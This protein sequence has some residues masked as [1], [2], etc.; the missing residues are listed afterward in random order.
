MK[1]LRGAI[2]TFIATRLLSVFLTLIGA[3]VLLLMMVRFV[4]GDFASVMLGPRATP[5]LREQITQQM[6]LDRN[7]F[8][9]LWLLLSNAATG[10]FGDDIISHRPILDI[11]LEALPNTLA[12]AFSAL[13]LALLV[14][15]PL[16]IIAALKPGTWVDSLLALISISFITTPTLVVAII[17]FLVF[18]TGLHWLPVAGAGAPDDMLDR[19]R[20]LILPSV[21]LAVGWVGYI[22]RLVRAALLDTLTEQHVRTLRAYGVSEWRI[23]SIYALKLAFVPVVSILGIG[24]GDLIGSSVVA[25]IIFARPGLGSL[26]FNSIAQRNYPV[27]QACVVFIVGFYIVANLVVDMVNAMLDPRIAKSMSA[28]GN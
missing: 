20:H 1:T 22:S 8:E 10:D 18:A 4:P 2:A 12:L 19:L 27:V 28:G 15:I 3:A 9:Q 5:A 14:G 23:V 25:E 13:G 6:G 7:F 26:I 21:A 16:G 17:L 11:V 24:F